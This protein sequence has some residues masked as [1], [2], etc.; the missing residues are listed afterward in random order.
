[1]QLIRANQKVT[2]NLSCSK[3]RIDHEKQ[4]ETKNEKVVETTK[5]TRLIK[6]RIEKYTCKRCKYSIKF[7]NNIKFHEHIRIR[8]A[9]KSKTIVSFFLQISKSIV[10]FFIFSA[11]SFHSIISSSVTSSK[12]LSFSISTSEIVRE[13]SKNVSFSSSIATFATSKK[14][15]F[16]AEIVS[17]FVIASKFFRFS[18]ATFKSMYKSLKNAN[19]VCSSISSRISSSRF[20][21]TVNDLFH[22]FVEKSSSFDLQS[23]QNKSLFF[24]N[25]DKCNFVNKCDFIQSRITSYFHAIILFAF[26]SIK[27]ET[28]ASIHVSMKHST[29]TSFSRIFRFS[30]SSMRFFLSKVSRSFSVCKHFQ[31]R[32][33][34]YWSIDWIMSSVSRIENNEIFMKQRYWNFASFRSILKEY[35]LFYFEKVITLKKLKHVVCLFV[36]LAFSFY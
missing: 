27:F 13:R 26:K 24:R 30:F 10:S 9:K 14:S 23:S 35:W 28:F 2:R 29:R 15:I 36:L 17:R 3:A 4:N 11:S 1:M 21:F 16:W 12:F 33:V 32:F 18:I 31:K 6:K 7:D 5:K 20:Y 8:H 25:F 22:M 19:V 34:I